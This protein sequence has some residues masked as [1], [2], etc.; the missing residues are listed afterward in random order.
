VRSG[1]LSRIFRHEESGGGAQP[2]LIIAHPSSKVEVGFCGAG[3][4]SA[5]HRTVSVKR[6][7]LRLTL[8]RHRK[9]EL[10]DRI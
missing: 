1:H 2:A 6:G 5:K 8:I 7:T 9:K 10:V 3:V 4:G